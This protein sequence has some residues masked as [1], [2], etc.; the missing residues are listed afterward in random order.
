[1]PVILL[2]AAGGGLAGFFFGKGASGISDIV[3]Y[4]AVGFAAYVAAKQFKV[5]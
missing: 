2:A 4:S 1:M 5:I 3:K